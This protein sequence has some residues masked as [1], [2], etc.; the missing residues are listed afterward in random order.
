MRL[1]RKRYPGYRHHRDL[2]FGEGLRWLFWAVKKAARRSRDRKTAARFLAWV[3]DRYFVPLQLASDYQVSHHSPY[4][5][6]RDFIAEVME[7]FGVNAASD[8]VLLFKH[9]PKDPYEDYS[10]FIEQ[11]AARL[12]LGGRVLYCV[13]GHLPTILNSCTGVITINS[14]VGISALHHRRPLCV[15][16]TAIYGLEGLVTR[17]LA[18]FMKKPWTFVPDRELF[19]GFRNYHL[20]TTQAAGNFHRV[21]FRGTRTGLLWPR[22]AKFEGRP[23]R[24]PGTAK[25]EKLLTSNLAAKV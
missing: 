8:A 19:E 12:G 25:T 4:G 13:N 5:S 18:E 15:R 21:L 6:V 24:R 17:D 20:M 9:H 2:G 1:G 3:G 22:E 14:T 11:E 16:G 10:A 23:K 7:S